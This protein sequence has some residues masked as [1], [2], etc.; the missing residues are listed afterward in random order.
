MNLKNLFIY[1]SLTVLS[2]ALP[3]VDSDPSRAPAFTFTISTTLPTHTPPAQSVIDA[4]PVG[5][6]STLNIPSDVSCDRFIPFTNVGTGSGMWPGSSGPRV[7][8]DVDGVDVYRTPAGVIVDT[9]SPGFAIGKDTWTGTF[10]K[11]WS[12]VDQSP[13][14]RA[15]KYL[16]SSDL[17]YTGYW[18]TV[19]ITFK[20][21]SWNPIM[22]SEV[23]V[24]VYDTKVTCT[25]GNYPVD[26]GICRGGGTPT[27]SLTGAYLGVGYGRRGDGMTE[28]TP[29]VNPLFNVR[30]IWA[31]VGQTD[32]TRPPPTYR[33]N[34]RNGYI[35]TKTGIIWGLTARNTASFKFHRLTQF[36]TLPMDWNMPPV[37][38]AINTRTCRTGMFLPDTG[39]I[40]SYVSHPDI[41]DGDPE[42][43]STELS[44]ITLDMPDIGHAMGQ[45]R[46]D[47]V[48]SGGDV[49]P[50]GYQV[51]QTPAGG[52]VYMNTGSRFFNRF[53]TAVDAEM[54]YY[55]A[56]MI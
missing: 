31:V 40:N 27:G 14:N 21:L 43:P 8:L 44:L 46:Y 29:D 47:G 45:V 32:P 12:S 11:L 5:V 13:T 20:D 30:G 41:P 56:R 48:G 18:A 7:Y 37:C 51:R 23:R 17:L 3:A 36:S 54:G 24:L 52:R 55:G 22:R 35:V 4:R 53:E 1:A 16:S 10:H 39:I 50:A 26:N 19:N 28:C 25:S 38:L 33:C 9:G 49:L 34:Y 6:Q 42:M 15:W 2:T